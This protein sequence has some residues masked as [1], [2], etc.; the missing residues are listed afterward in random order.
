MIKRYRKSGVFKKEVIVL[1]G[2][3]MGD[4]ISFVIVLDKRSK[5]FLI[6]L[7]AVIRNFWLFFINFFVICGFK[8]YI[9]F[10][11]FKKVIIIDV[12]KLLIKIL[13]IFFFLIFILRFFVIFL[14][15]LIVL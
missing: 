11:I 5:K 8:R 6:S 13:V 2:K 7:D 3:I 15:F 4:I 12:I 9:N 1:I 10:M 14:L